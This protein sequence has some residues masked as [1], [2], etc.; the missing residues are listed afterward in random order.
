MCTQLVGFGM[1]VSISRSRTLSIAGGNTD[2]KLTQ[3][4]YDQATELSEKLGLPIVRASTE[5]VEGNKIERLVNIITL[6]EEIEVAW[7]ELMPGLVQSFKRLYPEMNETDIRRDLQLPH[8][9]IKPDCNIK[10]ASQLVELDGV[11]PYV[12]VEGL[13]VFPGQ[14]AANIEQGPVRRSIDVR[15]VAVCATYT[16]V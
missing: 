1:L 8:P 9:A 6:R 14:F 3:A 13:E 15:E 4:V 10:Q 12:W 2:P 16:Q 5:S 7:S 11:A